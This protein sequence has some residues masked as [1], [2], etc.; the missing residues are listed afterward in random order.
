MKRACIGVDSLSGTDAGKRGLPATFHQDGAN[1][2]GDDSAA[3]QQDDQVV[4]HALATLRS[5]GSVKD[6]IPQEPCSTWPSAIFASLVTVAWESDEASLLPIIRWLWNDF[7]VVTPMAIMTGE[8]HEPGRHRLWHSERDGDKSTAQYVRFNQTFADGD[9]PKGQS[10]S[11]TI[12]TQVVPLQMDVLSRYADG[13]VKSAILTAA[14]PTIAAGATLQ[15]T[16]STSSPSTA[17]AVANNAALAQGY[18]LTVNMNISGLGAATINAAQ[19]L[20]AALAS[21][22]FEYFAKARW[23]PRSGSMYRSP[24]RCMSHSMSSPMPTAASRPKCSSR[25]IPPWVVRRRRA[26]Q[27]PVHRRGRRDTVQHDQ[28]DAVSVPG[29]G[30]GHQPGQQ[31]QADAERPA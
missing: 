2:Y 27:Q 31:R 21:G 5:A 14:V 9:L 16:Q 4:D 19:K 18:D 13:S 28:P 12:G 30:A 25:T 3:R 7:A 23:P 1:R 8:G 29:L 24:G 6:A 26:V 20:S 17:A 11:A 10:V 15:G 22:D